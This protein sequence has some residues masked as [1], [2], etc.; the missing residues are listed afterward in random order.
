MTECYLSST[1]SLRNPQVVIGKLYTH[2]LTHT[3]THTLRDIKSANILVKSDDCEC[4]IGDL[5]FALILDP[6]IDAKQLANAG[7]VGQVII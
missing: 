4:V 1:T 3:H 5:G 6:S 2:L 7:Q